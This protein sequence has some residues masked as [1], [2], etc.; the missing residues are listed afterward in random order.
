MR[1]FWSK[2]ANVEGDDEVKES[3]FIE[4]RFKLGKVGT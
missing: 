2:K 4:R 3:N 1:G